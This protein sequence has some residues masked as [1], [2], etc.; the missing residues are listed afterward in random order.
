VSP[1]RLPSP[2]RRGPKGKGSSRTTKTETRPRNT[3][4]TSPT[5]GHSWTMETKTLRLVPTGNDA[6]QARRN[7]RIPS[8]ACPRRS[9]SI[10]TMSRPPSSFLCQTS[11]RCT[12]THSRMWRFKKCSTACSCEGYSGYRGSNLYARGKPHAVV[13]TQIY[14]LQH[15]LPAVTGR[16]PSGVTLYVV[17]KTY[18]Y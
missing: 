5:T 12:A 10:P 7:P 11:S 13:K 17:Q 16:K 2:K 4:R 14:P 6:S 9:H 3:R 1:R 8:R 15:V 18:A